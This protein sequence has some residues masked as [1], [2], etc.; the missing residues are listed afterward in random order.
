[1]AVGGYIRKVW[2]QPSAR[3]R[4]TTSLVALA[5]ALV[6]SASAYG[7]SARPDC[8]AAVLDDWTKGTLGSGYAPDCYEQAL[9]ALPEDL[10][11][12]TTAAD[13]ITRAAIDASR[14]A[15]GA[16][17]GSVSARQLA[18]TQPADDELRSFPTEVAALGALLTVLLAC[19]LGAA[20]L[21][22]RRGR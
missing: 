14:N 12:Y 8:A 22:R 7:G 6:L 1:M 9:D 17:A 2:R 5:T 10:R 4:L 16:T 21:R 15:N 19:G 20:V 11:A 3:R 13:D 18:D